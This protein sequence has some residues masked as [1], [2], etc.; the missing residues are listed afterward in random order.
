VYRGA[1]TY[2]PKHLEDFVNEDFGGA[3]VTVALLLGAVGQLIGG[4]VSQRWPLERIAPVLGLA[5]LPALLLTGVAT[6][7]ALVLI[8]SL[9]IFLYFANQ[10]VFTGLIADYSP[11]GAVGRSFGISFFAGFGL[12]STGGVIAG[13][14]VDRWD[15]QAAFLGLSAF[16]VLSALL[17]IALWVMAERRRGDLIAQPVAEVAQ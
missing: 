9:F 10:P 12:G 4:R 15:T 13:A 7:P 11:P 5:A 6:G 16:M 1:I 8:S 14:L 2:L 3:L 17:S